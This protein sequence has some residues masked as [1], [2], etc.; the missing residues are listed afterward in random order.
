A[1]SIRDALVDETG[2]ILAFLPGQGEIERTVRLL[3]DRVPAHV[4]LAPLY[5][6]MEGRDQDAAIKPAPAGH[7]KVVLATSIAETSITIDGV[8]VV[9]DSGLARLPKYVPATGLT[10]LE[11]V[12]TSR[13]SADQR[14][15]RAGRTEPGVAIRLWHQGQTASLPAFSPPEILEADLSGLVLDAAAWGVTD[16]ATLS[17]LD[18]PP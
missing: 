8:R 3:E 16:P 2:S 15:G 10:R 4:I 13:A 9:I 17:L 6:A 18:K 5:G 11:T 1:R 12:R 14:A 7:R